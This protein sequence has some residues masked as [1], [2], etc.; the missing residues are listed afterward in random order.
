VFFFS[1]SEL[2]QEHVLFYGFFISYMTWTEHGE[3]LNI[4]VLFD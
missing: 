3:F 2:I 1:T 4:Y